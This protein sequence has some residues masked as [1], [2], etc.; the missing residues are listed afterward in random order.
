[1][2]RPSQSTWDITVPELGE[3]WQQGRAVPGAVLSED[4]E[5]DIE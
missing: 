4:I 1:M 3:V 5:G 2:I